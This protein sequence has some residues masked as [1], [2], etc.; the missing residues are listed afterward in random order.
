LETAGEVGKVAISHTTKDLLGEEFICQ[1]AG[2]FEA[3]N[4]GTMERYFVT[5]L[6]QI[7]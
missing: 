3:K 5:G 1:P 4:I 7:S 2:T 6:H